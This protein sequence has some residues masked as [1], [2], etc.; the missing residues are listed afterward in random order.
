MD[1]I[2]SSVNESPVIS[3]EAGAALTDARGK[4]VKFDDDGKIVIA[5]AGDAAVGIAVISNAE[6]IEKGR[7][8]EVQIRAVGLVKA[9]AAISCGDKLAPDANGALVP[10]ASGTYIGTAIQEAP[11]AGAFIQAI[12]ERGCIA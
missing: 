1:F 11:S 8:L 5:G 9:G 3:A 6:T 12:I 10:A 2:T 7:Y 4:A